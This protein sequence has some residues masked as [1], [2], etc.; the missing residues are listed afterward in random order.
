MSGMI[1]AVIDLGCC[2]AIPIIELGKTWIEGERKARLLPCPLHA[3]AP[4]LLAALKLC[5][6]RQRII[7]LTGNIEPCDMHPADEEVER[8]ASE[9]ITHAEGRG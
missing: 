2:R 5:R 7:A 9:A 8:V 4:S 1:I 3:A 6:R